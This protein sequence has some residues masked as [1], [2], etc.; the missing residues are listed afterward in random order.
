MY[1][2]LKHSKNK[3]CAPPQQRLDVGSVGKC[4]GQCVGKKV[5][6]NVGDDNNHNGHGNCPGFNLNVNLCTDTSNSIDRSVRN[7]INNDSTKCKPKDILRGTGIN[8]NVSLSPN[9]YSLV[10]IA[11]HHTILISSIGLVS[12]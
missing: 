11:V 7:G 6:K 5:E 3:D 12:P 1:R 8:Y 4:V 9:Q 2:N 10:K